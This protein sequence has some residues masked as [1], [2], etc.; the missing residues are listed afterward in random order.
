MVKL[1]HQII[2]SNIFLKVAMKTERPL[3]TTSRRAREREGGGGKFFQRSLRVVGCPTGMIHVST[4][5]CTEKKDIQCFEKLG[6][7]VVTFFRK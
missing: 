7:L 1:Q 2:I 5:L 3:S 4:I 6:L